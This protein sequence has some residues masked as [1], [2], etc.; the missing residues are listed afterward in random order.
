[1][2]SSVFNT[3]QFYKPTEVFPEFLVVLESQ[4][5]FILSIDS[6]FIFKI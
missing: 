6:K 3:T 5:T 4:E 2:I 1:M